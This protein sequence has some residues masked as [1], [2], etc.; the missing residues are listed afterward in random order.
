MGSRQVGWGPLGDG[1]D[2]HN[3][4]TWTLN[5]PGIDGGLGPG[6]ARQ[7]VYWAIANVFVV[8]SDRSEAAVR[9]DAHEAI[10]HGGS[11]GLLFE[12]EMDDPRL[13]DLVNNEVGLEIAGELMERIQAGGYAGW[14]SPHDVGLDRLGNEQVAADMRA[15]VNAAL[16]S[17]GGAAVWIGSDGVSNFNLDSHLTPYDY[18]GAA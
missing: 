6:N 5:Q 1:L 18:N 10:R 13:M 12:G 14:L 17:G 11:T 7:H 4:R 2:F 3:A 8:G 9:L 16:S 15:M